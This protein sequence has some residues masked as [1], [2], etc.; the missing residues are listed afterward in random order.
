MTVSIMKLSLTTLVGMTGLTVT[1]CIMTLMLTTLGMSVSMQS[2]IMII[3][4]APLNYIS[5]FKTSNH[6]AN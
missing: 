1:L 6:F 4:V 3:V 5:M 2:V